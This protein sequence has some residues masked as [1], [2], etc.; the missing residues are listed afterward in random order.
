MTFRSNFRRD[1]SLDESGEFSIILKRQIKKYIAEDPETVHQMAI[2]LLV[3]L[4]I[5]RSQTSIF[6]QAL[7][8]LIIGALFFGLR[9][10]EYTKVTGKRMTKK[11]IVENIRFFHQRREIPKEKRLLHTL[12]YATSV[13]ITFVLQKNG[14][15]YATIT[16][17]ASG[18][19]VCPV[20]AWAA[21][22]SRILHYK[23]G[24]TKSDID[25]FVDEEEN[26]YHIT[27]LDVSKHLK[28]L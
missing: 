17:H 16:Q 23:K 28:T 20:R 10:C 11:L 8:Q 22:V 4:K 9:S 19:E 5:W 27:A 25:L 7:A 15:K 3:F 26:E 2:S 21:V 12:K 1:P 13:S 24:T 6:S 14:T 18:K